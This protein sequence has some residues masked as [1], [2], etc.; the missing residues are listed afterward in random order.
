MTRISVL[1][2]AALLAALLAAQITGEASAR[3]WPIVEGG[4]NVAE[5][6]QALI[7]ATSRFDSDAFYLFEPNPPPPQFTDAIVFGVATELGAEEFFDP[8]VFMELRAEGLYGQYFWQIAPI[9][10]GRLVLSA[11]WHSWRGKIYDVAIDGQTPT[12]EAFVQQMQAAREAGQAQDRL[13]MPKPDDWI[14]PMVVRNAQSGALWLIDQERSVT[15]DWRVVTV[16]EAGFAVA[17]A[18]HFAPPLAPTREYGRETFSLLPRQVRRFAE[19][20]D[21]TLG[22]D[23]DGTL[24]PIDQKRWRQR[25]TISNVVLRPWALHDD[26]PYRPG[27]SRARINA[28][29]DRWARIAPSFAETRAAIAHQYPVAERALADYNRRRLA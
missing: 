28:E 6:Q 3:D 23:G 2:V 11:R 7:L 4:E 13:L 15:A 26:E 10:S 14:P 16:G 12:P 25:D 5:C 19:L 20:I 9:N 21:A 8:S 22:Q 17:C 24:R 27:N 1:L 18:I 29:L